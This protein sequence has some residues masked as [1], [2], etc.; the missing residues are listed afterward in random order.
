MVEQG[1]SS[2]GGD[3]CPA[4][5]HDL[6]ASNLR[7]RNGTEWFSAEGKRERGGDVSATQRRQRCVRV[8]E[9]NERSTRRCGSKK[10]W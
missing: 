4:F 7:E 3:S 2:G 8:D 9:C 6:A 10:C 5:R 1:W